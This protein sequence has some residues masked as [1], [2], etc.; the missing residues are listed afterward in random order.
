[1]TTKLRPLL[2]HQVDAAKYAYGRKRIALFMEMRLGKTMVTIRW[3]TSYV[4]YK[5]LIIAPLTVLVS[6]YDEL[7]LEGIPS[8]HIHMITGSK[9]NRLNNVRLQGGHWNLM[10]YEGLLSCSEIADLKWTHVIL[11]ESTRIRSPQTQTTNLSCNRFRFVPHK[12]ILSGLPNPESSLDYFC[13][14]KFL[15]GQFFGEKNFWYFRKKFYQRFG[16]DWIPRKGTLAK[17][18][19]EV[20]LLSFVLTRKQAGIGSRKMYEK[21]VIPMTPIQKVVYKR[22]EKD[23]AFEYEGQKFSTKW[24]PVKLQWLSR[25]AG[26]FTPELQLVSE[27]K[28]KEVYRLLTEELKNENVVIWFHFNK[29]LFYVKKYLREKG[30]TVTSISGSNEY[31]ERDKRVKKF[32]AGKCRVICCQVKCGRYGL[33]LAN[34][35]TAIYFSNN[36]EMEDRKQSED[37]IVHPS[38]KEP[39]LIIDMIMENTIDETV[40]KTLKEKNINSRFFMQQLISN[41]K[42]DYE[43]KKV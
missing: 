18:K 24:I 11:D 33:N 2:P 42:N 13:Q 25:I 34:S 15:Y 7:L 30:I 35:S 16:Y 36:Y 22:C 37:R 31:E 4:G 21:C 20:H 17:I 27:A 6:W 26:G 41:W 19:K 23:F 40:L 39:L 32:Q 5:A 10:N 38:K 1:M 43:K 12:A 8:A 28:V 14:F 9:L 29:E 3:V